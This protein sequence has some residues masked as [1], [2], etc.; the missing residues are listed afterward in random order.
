M[1]P[2]RRRPA[3]RSAIRLLNLLLAVTLT[4]GLYVAASTHPTPVGGFVGG[5]AATASLPAEGPRWSPA[6][7]R[8]FPGFDGTRRLSDRVVVVGL[9][10]RARVMGFDEALARG[11]SE[12]R[13]DD[14]WTIGWE[15]R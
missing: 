12:T 14:V 4:A 6:L 3:K 5:V 13:A 9:D 1:H 11:E 7:A 15:R 8:R 10:G 2:A